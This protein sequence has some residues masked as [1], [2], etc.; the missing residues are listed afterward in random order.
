MKNIQILSKQLDDFYK[1]NIPYNHQLSQ[2]IK[3][4]LFQKPPFSRS[5]SY[6]QLLTTMSF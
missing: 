4:S 2:E 6:L 3:L 1:A 5:Q